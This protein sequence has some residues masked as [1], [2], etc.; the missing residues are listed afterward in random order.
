LDVLRDAA[1]DG[2]LGGPT[3]PRALLEGCAQMRHRLVRLEVREGFPALDA[4]ELVR[5]VRRLEEVVL[6][7]ARLGASRRGEREQV[8]AQVVLAAGNAVNERGSRNHF[9]LVRG[10]VCACHRRTRRQHC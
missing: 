4:Q 7:T 1:P 2:D 5:R 3:F 10:R 6:E 9:A 8:I